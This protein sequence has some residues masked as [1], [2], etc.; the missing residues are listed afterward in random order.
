MHVSTAYVCGERSGTV[1]ESELDRGQTF[2]NGYEA[3]KA[4]AE[5]LV[6]AA[7]GAG[8]D[9]AIARP[10]IVVGRSSDGVVGAFDNIYAFIRLVIGGHVR[11][12]PIHAEAS[13]D[14]VP[15]DH[16]AAGLVAAAENGPAVSGRTLHLV[17]G[18]PVPLTA[19]IAAGL[20]YK[21]FHLPT[22][23]DASSFDPATLRPGEQRLFRQVTRLYANYLC[24]NPRFDAAEAVTRLGLACPPT[25][26]PF[27]RRLIDHGI[28]SGYFRE[29]RSVRG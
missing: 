5:R 14:L 10:S 8:L 2:A 12:L 25:G 22:V 19:L 24:R 20:A 28:A 29:W 26:E 3:S 18:E 15:I 1:L 27:L 16:V 7:A 11:V 17:S 4:A 13:L 6:A 21:Q 23:V 9:T